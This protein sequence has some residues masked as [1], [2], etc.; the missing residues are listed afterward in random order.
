MSVALL[1]A[2]MAAYGKSLYG[3]RGKPWG[4]TLHSPK[5]PA[6]LRRVFLWHGM[7]RFPLAKEYRDLPRSFPNL[8]P[9]S[10]ASCNG[11]R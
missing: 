3:P 11:R 9:A 6:G 1:G 8:K 5:A 7:S 2:L 10:R 4:K